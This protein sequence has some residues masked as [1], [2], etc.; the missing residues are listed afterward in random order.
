MN[1]KIYKFDKGEGRYKREKFHLNTYGKR[2]QQD[3]TSGTAYNI[4]D[5]LI[6]RSGL[7]VNGKI[8]RL[9]VYDKKHITINSEYKEKGKNVSDRVVTM[10][11][12]DG[13]SEMLVDEFINICCKGS[14]RFIKIR[15]YK[16]VIIFI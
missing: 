1:I 4:S 16:E 5:N 2:K 9:V 6:E 11:A 3:Y 14:N 15:V 10:N 8:K 7:H 12:K 13:Q